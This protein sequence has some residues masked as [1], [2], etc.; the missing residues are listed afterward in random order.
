MYIT[1]IHVS[2]FKSLVDFTLGLTKFNCLI[3]LNGT[4]KSTV[5]QFFDFIS[6]QMK[7]DISDWLKQRH[8][9]YADLNSKLINKKNIDFEITFEIEPKRKVVWKAS[10]NRSD[11]RCTSESVDWE[12]ASGVATI[13]NVSK[14]NYY[15]HS[16]SPDGT[17]RGPGLAAVMFD[18][19]GS[20][21]SQLKENHLPDELIR[22]KKALVGLHSLDLLSPELLR[23]KTREAQGSLGLGGERLSAFLHDLDANRIEDLGLA[24]KKAYSSFDR[25]HVKTLRSGWKQLQITESFGAKKLSTES[26]QIND[27]LLRL[28]AIFSQLTID[29]SFLLLDEIE[30]GINP[31]LVE[32][33]I[34]TLVTAPPQV[35]VT[36]HSPMI[37]NFL[38]DEVAKTGVIYLY[39]DGDGCTRS[40]RF[41]DI[42]SMNKKLTTMGPGEAYEDTNLYELANEIN[43]LNERG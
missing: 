2:N 5:L 10:F 34:D 35:L 12:F 36:T 30:N 33:L 39:K 20:I 37:L 19:E 43:S 18:Y 24:L 22:L 3:G 27:G 41:F 23:Q 11:L 40:I 17:A 4:G 31:E 26:R 21:L 13:L 29:Q 32:Y 7:G 25:L 1:K 14:G 6:Q 9:S 42:P 15:Y 16:I 38:D 28:L 8:W